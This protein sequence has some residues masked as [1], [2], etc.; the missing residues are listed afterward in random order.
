MKTSDMPAFPTSDFHPN[1]GGLTKREWFAGQAL[2]GMLS[3]PQFLDG[4]TKCASQ[5]SEVA[6]SIACAVWE[7]ADAMIDEIER[8]GK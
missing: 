3:N 6:P 7:I 2:C 4:L 1:L 5:D 8:T